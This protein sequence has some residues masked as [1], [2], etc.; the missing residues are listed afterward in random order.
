MPSFDVDFEVFCGCGAGLCNQSKG[1][2]SCNGLTVTVE[3]CEKCIEKAREEGY[4]EG[5]EEARKEFE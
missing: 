1:T 5:Y 3:P 2:S 4:D